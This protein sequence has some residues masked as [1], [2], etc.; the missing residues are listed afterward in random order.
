MFHWRIYVQLLDLFIVHLTKN[1]QIEG[2]MLNMKFLEHTPFIVFFN[3]VD[4]FQEKLKVHP[5]TKAY[6]DY[7][8]SQNYEEAV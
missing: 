7:T 2:Q 5:L 1:S 6:R 3:K 4:L 8:G